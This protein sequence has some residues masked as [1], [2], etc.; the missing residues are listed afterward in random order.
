M[1]GSSDT[2]DT[3]GKAPEKRSVD[4]ALK[5]PKRSSKNEVENDNVEEGST[6]APDSSDTGD[7]DSD[8][9]KADSGNQSEDEGMSHSLRV[10]DD[11]SAVTA[12]G[13]SDAATA[14]MGHDLPPTTAD[15]P[16][17]AEAEEGDQEAPSDDEAERERLAMERKA[18]AAAKRK[19]RRSTEL[20]DTLAAA[21]DVVG[22]MSPVALI[23]EES[24]PRYQSH[25][26]AA[27]VAKTKLSSKP[28]GRPNKDEPEDPPPTPAHTKEEI[29]ESK[30]SK[31]KSIKPVKEVAKEVLAK[32]VVVVAE[33]VEAEWVQCDKCSKWRKLPSHTKSDS[34]PDKWFCSMNDWNPDNHGCE[35]PEDTDPVST[36][37][38]LSLKEPD[39]GDGDEIPNPR[40]K[41]GR[42]DDGDHEGDGVDRKGFTP[43]SHA[44]SSR[45]ARPQ[46]TATR[47]RDEDDSDG[48][49]AVDATNARRKLPAGGSRAPS[50]STV[51]V[52]WVQCNKC[53]KW[54]RVPAFIK[55]SDLPDVWV[56]SQNTWATAFARC[57]AKEE[58]DP[59]TVGT[60][61]PSQGGQVSRGAADRSAVSKARK[62]GP[63]L[64]GSAPVP[65]GTKT[66][67]Q[68]VQCERKNCK[69]WRKVPAS[70]DMSAFPDKWF[71]EMNKWDLDRASCDG[72]E[73]TD[74]ESEQ[75]QHS[76]SRSQL[77]LANSK[78]PGALSYRRIIF[79]TDG[80]I[81]ASFSEKNK[82]GFGLF[83]YTECV[84]PVDGEDYVEPTRRLSY[85]WSSAFSDPALADSTA[86]PA[87]Q[88]AAL[89]TPFI[90]ALDRLH[91]REA[92]ESSLI[93][94]SSLLGA[95]RRLSV[96]PGVSNGD[97]GQSSLPPPP[98]P[99]GLWHKK[100]HKMAQVLNGINI[101]DRI[102]I[103]CRIVR[104]CLAA[105]D[106]AGISMAAL[107]DMI[108]GSVFHCPKEEACRMSLTMPSL[109]I[110]VHRLEESAEVEI[111]IGSSGSVMVV[112][113]SA[114]FSQPAPRLDAAAGTVWAKCGVPLKF[115]KAVPS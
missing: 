51:N 11:N 33:P 110:V 84:R 78:G 32:E 81:R 70:V 38:Q 60:T 83:S 50:R 45:K 15:A 20:L 92:E 14:D 85:W 88:P 106:Q 37:T 108:K 71:C 59:D 52:D 7:A 4:R 102:R 12:V 100:V 109:K 8:N 17:A 62:G 18:A 13:S 43:R 53:N 9:D 58:S 48:E 99:S 6:V 72:P 1:P 91:L 34:L 2:Q 96:E 98:P 67:T 113:A 21:G 97:A 39:G 107:L 30:K 5:N 55:V 36:E 74:S 69:K 114:P 95:A 46:G 25:R 27:M 79:G 93:T 61:I 80:R 105:S 29:A 23:E 56:C 19:R 86:A 63:P 111:S 49:G 112:L 101:L 57:S 40:R 26:A 3:D 68:W 76:G 66:V 87:T 54:R 16:D 44:K 77:I 64:P 22:D 24:T 65:E 115:R 41:N 10:E 104:S 28:G 90:K 42:Y 75:K 89:D 94:S 35:D 47:R 31:S 82:N 103:E 73:E